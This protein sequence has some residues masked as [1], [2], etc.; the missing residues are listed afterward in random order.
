MCQF[1]FGSPKVRTHIHLSTCYT[2]WYLPSLSTFHEEPQSSLDPSFVNEY[3]PNTC[4]S[5]HLPAHHFHNLTFLRIDLHAKTIAEGI[6]DAIGRS[7]AGRPASKIS[8]RILRLSTIGPAA[9][10]P[11][12]GWGAGHTSVS[13]LLNPD[14][15]GSC[16]V[17]QSPVCGAIAAHVVDDPD[18]IPEAE[19]DGVY[20]LYTPYFQY[21]I[22]IPL[23]CKPCPSTSPSTRSLP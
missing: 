12:P 22:E 5:L 17:A 23:I 8:W 11:S 20:Q 14:A 18:Y 1:S 10:F 4:P 15:V 19:V 9:S 2:G 16:C 6:V 3:H 21:S 7:E 13:F